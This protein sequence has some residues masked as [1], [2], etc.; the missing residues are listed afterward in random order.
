MGGMDDTDRCFDL[1][2]FPHLQGVDLTLWL[3]IVIG[4][5]ALALGGAFLASHSG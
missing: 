2:H 1:D 4:V 5:I 3:Q